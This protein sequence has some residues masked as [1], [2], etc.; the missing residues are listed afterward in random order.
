MAPETSAVQFRTVEW[1]TQRVRLQRAAPPD[2]P[3][4]QK[5]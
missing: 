5:K 1:E 4:Q 2:A 3:E